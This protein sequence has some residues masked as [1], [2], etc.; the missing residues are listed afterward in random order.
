[1]GIPQR[2]DFDACQFSGAA[3]GNE[4]GT[5]PGCVSVLGP[6]K[7]DIT[8]E[9]LKEQDLLTVLEPGRP[10][11]RCRQ[12]GFSGGLPPC[13]QRGTFFLSCPHMAFPLRA[14]VPG[15]SPPYHTEH[16]HT[17]SEP[18]HRTSVKLSH[19]FKGCTGVRT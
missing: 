6:P 14:C 12:L 17:G 3:L 7:Q 5:I 19:L 15:A 16:Q 11:S 9:G 18:T 13:Q 1:M 10:G 4:Q 8:D 2:A